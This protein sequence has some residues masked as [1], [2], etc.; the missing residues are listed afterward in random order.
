MSH[1]M[2]F[3]ELQEK[4]D[5]LKEAQELVAQAMELVREAVDETGL[6]SYAKT[7]ALAGL[8]QMF[9]AER[10]ESI[11]YLVTMMVR[12]QENIQ[13]VDKAEAAVRRA[14]AERLQREASELFLSMG[15]CPLCGREMVSAVY[16]DASQSAYEVG[17]T[18]LVC[19][20]CGGP[21]HAQKLEDGRILYEKGG[22][23]FAV[24]A[25]EAEAEDEDKEWPKCS[26]CG[27][28]L[29]DDDEYCDECFPSW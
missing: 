20:H 19:S 8:Q 4:I 29:M 22:H 18:R 25:E 3:N 1:E 28:P 13:I 23:H 15:D 24:D 2:T 14:E 27:T 6:E 11:E 16:Y 10:T 21:E 7:Y 17:G 5:A 9:Y 26:T 12:M